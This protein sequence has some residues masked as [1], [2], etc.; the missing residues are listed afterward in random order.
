MREQTWIVDPASG[1]LV[2]EGLVAEEALALAGDFLPPGRE[3]NCA[4]PLASV[5]LPT[6][7]LV[8][9][10]MLRVASIYHGSVVDG[11]GRRS[12]CQVQGCPIRCD[13]CAVP[14]THDPQ[15]G[16]RV[17]VDDVVALLLDPVGVPRDGVTITG[18]EP[19]AQPAGLLALLQRLKLHNIHIVVYTGYTLEALARQ[20]EP[21]ILEA[22]E[23]IDLLIDGPYVARLTHGAGEWRG[24]RN[25]RVIPHP[26]EFLKTGQPP[27]QEAQRWT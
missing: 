8:R 22:L 16:H 18:G 6:T 7:S 19:F 26:A 11:P 21:D 17:S 9:E 1:D 27:R 2:V 15:G 4:Q 25:Q 10:P 13:L 24:S 12:V 3:L 14:Q 20:P 5:P 23:L